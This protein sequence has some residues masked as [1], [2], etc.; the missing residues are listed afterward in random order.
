M[1]IDSSTKNRI[2]INSISLTLAEASAMDGGSPGT[3]R[4]LTTFATYMESPGFPVAN[5]Y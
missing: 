5:D 2:I 4:Y 1:D 3:P